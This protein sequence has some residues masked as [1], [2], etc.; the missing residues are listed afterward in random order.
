MKVFGFNE[1]GIELST[2]PE[3]SIGSDTDWQSATSALEGALKEKGLSYVVNAGEGAFYGPKIDIKLKDA[4]K[5]A[6]QC[7]TIQCDFALPKRFHLAYIDAQGKE[8][9]PV[10]LHRV[11]LGSLERFIGALLEHYNAE[12]PLW[13]APLQAVV[14]PI[15]DSL[16]EYADEV[17]RQLEKSSLRAEVDAGSE[18]LNKRIR[19]A[20]L[21]KVPYILVVGE[22]EEKQGAVAVRKKGEGDLGT[23]KLA[24]FI[25]EIKRQT[26]QRAI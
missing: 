15:K 21:N 18:T 12:L 19:N 13:L 23:K 25:N 17:K 22:R 3:K 5:R 24:E 8:Q 7:A 9:Q 6:W 14:I 4:L 2:R 10:M 26:E 1:V 20:E 11:V 16:G